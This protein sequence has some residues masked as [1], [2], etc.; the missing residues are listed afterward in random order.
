MH[1]PISLI[2]IEKP[3]SVVGVCAACKPERVHQTP[4][5]GLYWWCDFASPYTQQ[6]HAIRTPRRA[7]SGHRTH[8]MSGLS[9]QELPIQLSSP[10]S[11]LQLRP[12][13][14]FLSRFRLWCWRWSGGCPPWCSSRRPLSHPPPRT[15]SP[16]GGELRRPPR[17]RRSSSS[18][19]SPRASHHH[20]SRRRP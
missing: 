1:A 20:H 6:S 11:S 19:G 10:W 18:W 8:S 17:P 12:K 5:T 2:H 13:R 7:R 4:P 15:V 16:G 3:L 14:A 9:S